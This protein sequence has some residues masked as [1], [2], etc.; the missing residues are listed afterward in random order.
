MTDV[1][2]DLAFGIR[3][4][5]K[6]PGTAALAIAALAL[7][8]GLTATMFSIIQG[9]FLRGLPFHEPDR[10]VALFRQRVGEPGRQS[11]PADDVLDWRDGQH[12]FE[13]VGAFRTQAASIAGEFAAERARLVLITPNTLR[14]LRVAPVVGRDFS[15]ADAQ[16]GAGRV[17][18]ISYHLWT[19]VFGR[20][21]GVIGRVV[22]V[23]GQPTTIVGVAPERFGFPVAHDLWMPLA[24][25][26][27][28]K[29]GDGPTVDVVARLKPGVSREAAETEIRA[30]AAR[31]EAQHDRNTGFTAGAASY[32]D[33]FLGDEIVGTLSL[34]LAAVLGVMLI[35]CA[36]VATLQLARAAE[37][38]REVAVRTALGAS[39]TRIVRQL[40]VEGFVVAA[41]GAGLGL[42]IASVGIGLFNR[43][44]VDTN[45]PFW[46]DIR[47]DGVVLAFVTALTVV[48]AI[49]ASLVPALRATRQDTNAV[50]K[51]EGR[52]ST[53]LRLGRFVRNLVV[54]E[55]FVSCTLLVV[56]GLMLRSILSTGL[57]R[58]PYATDDVLVASFNA[59]GAKY[60]SEDDRARFAERL[61]TAIGSLPGVTRASL[62]SGAPESG[63][64]QQRLAVEGQAY[65]RPNDRPQVRHRVVTPAYFE[66]LDIRA[67][68]GRSFTAADARG[69]QPVTVITADLA[70]RLFP[71]ADPIGR[72]I[73]TGDDAAAPWRTIVGILPQLV[74]TRTLDDP[75]AMAFTP[76][77]QTNELPFM[78]VARTAQEPASLVAALRGKVAEVDPD[79]AVFNVNSLAGTYWQSAWPVRT[80]GGLFMAFGVAAL[81]LATAGLYGVM[82]FSVRQRTQEMGVRMALGATRARVVGMVFWQGLW[83][84]ALGIGLA[85]APAWWLAGTIGSL[86]FDLPAADLTIY[87]AAVLALSLTGGA[88]ALVP[89]IRAA[90]VD[91]LAALRQD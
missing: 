50:L 57:A 1:L 61:E 3:M 29:R 62:A 35:A 5:R 20:D 81:V 51:D 58:Y 22:R 68:R 47:I 12:S 13:A 2:Q 33:R 40:L 90:S 8:I 4:L 63:C 21:R 25:A 10:L 65:A 78:I 60:V 84:V 37:R 64:C 54:I 46:I 48:A 75:T 79:L 71:Q 43:A 72:R 70:E 41:L 28:V 82:S 49:V 15:E 67:V 59:D 31:L 18:I 53:G 56:S 73:R 11:V 30:I 19:S 89:A 88:A 52:G 36:N 34:M 17:A 86:A 7:G 26:R 9:V 6:R 66:T 74:R 87:A 42:G 24:L 69:S 76:L 23:T 14:M 80:F 77:A 55:V 45:P 91:P 83:R 38:T 85:L 44:I 27:P 32:F 39:R 16:V